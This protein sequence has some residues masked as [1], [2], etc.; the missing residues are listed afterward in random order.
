M[1]IDE[2]VL[3]WEIPRLGDLVEMLA[4]KSGLTWRPREA[5]TPPDVLNQTDVET[6]GK[7]LDAAAAQFD[8]E[9][10]PIEALYRDVEQLICNAAPAILTLPGAD[11][12]D[13]PRFLALLKGSPRRVKILCS[14][15]AVRSF[16]LEKVR[17]M[18]CN[19]I[20]A[21][22]IAP[23]QDGLREAGVPEERMPRVVQAILREQLAGAR[24][25]YGW[26]LRLSP[27]VSFIQHIRQGNLVTPFISMLGAQAVQ[28]VISLFSWWLLGL[29]VFQGRFEWGW[30]SAWAL[31][32][33]TAI[34]F[35]L[36][37]L[38]A[39]NSLSVGSGNI[40]KQRLLYGVLKLEP[41]EIRHQGAGQFLSRVMEASAVELLALSGGFTA[42]MA[43]IQVCTAAWVLAQG[44][45]G[46]VHALLLL[47]WILILAGVSVVFVYQSFA[48][49]GAYRSMTN[50]L[51]EHMV[52]HRTRLA[53]QAQGH[54][55][56]EEDSS[57]SQYLGLTAQQGYTSMFLAFIPRGWIL[58]S[59]AWL[60]VPL[61]GAPYS[62]PTL[63]VSLG[64][65]MLA[66]QALQMIIA[67]VQSVMG[68]GIALQQTRP[69][70]QAAARRRDVQPLV[71]NQSAAEAAE[72][73]GA[74]APNL[75]NALLLARGVN[76]RYRQQGRLALQD[77][78]L[79][80]RR[81]DRVLLEGPSGGGKST[82]AA[83]LAGLREAEAGLLLLHGLDQK[84]LGKEEWRRRVSVAPQFQENHVFTGT[85]AFNLLMGRRWPPYP[86]D[87]H[88]ADEICRELGLGELLERMP[89]RFQQM[90]GES[91]W[92]L[93]HGERSR[94]YIARALL[95]NA[96]IIFLDESFG[97]LDPQN[98]QRAMRCVLER[99][100]TVVVIAHP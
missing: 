89:A 90:V 31:I 53:Q 57:L 95:Q 92:Q 97:A 50:D 2:T 45:G 28:Q 4:R 27:G 68:M 13:A 25:V 83:V 84:T 10:E 42:V 81:G 16:P 67:G 6:L 72:P 63:A 15:F 36:I 75:E 38:Q 88:T 5:P 91:G 39:Q 86:V 11:L 41:E 12:G 96:D 40:F 47:L 7:W 70:L 44:A 74:P 71:L 26:L 20:E 14:D 32:L 77:C 19:R 18:L 76:F 78:S 52:G 21:P 51:V 33:F 85:F 82:L 3:V 46:L 49:S 54:W 80:I 99:A 34:P 93:S 29:G 55:H 59:V 60:V 17:Q 56:D 94:L 22:L 65:I 37:S 35:Q 9:A 73:Q 48:W 30:L 58:L 43:L 66:Y 1:R 79:Q 61:I 69:L 100:N 23:L 62:A 87:L 64:G 24:V 8:L 98:L